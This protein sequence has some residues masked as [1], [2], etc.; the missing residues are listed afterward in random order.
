MQD[1]VG[2][3][4]DL[5]PWRTYKIS[6]PEDV[7]LKFEEALVLAKGF[8]LGTNRIEC[9]EAICVEFTQTYFPGALYVRKEADKAGHTYKVNSIDTLI[10]CGFRCVACEHSQDLEIHH[11]WPRGA[12]G[13]GR[14]EDIHCHDNLV[15]LCRGCHAAI[16][17]KWREHVEDL[18]AK[19]RKAEAE[20]ALYGFVLT[21]K[22]TLGEKFKWS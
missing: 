4:R 5:R 8:G 12:H 22:H 21:S 15:V 19:R 17:P 3:E 11:I 1:Q 18:K 2:K 14:P 16:Q 13:D 20:V 6:L 10:R 7:A 9:L